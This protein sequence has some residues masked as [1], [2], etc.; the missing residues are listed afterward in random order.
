MTGAGTYWPETVCCPEIRWSTKGGWKGTGYESRRR[1]I[2]LQLPRTQFRVSD[3]SKKHSSS[4]KK[5]HMPKFELPILDLR[6]WHCWQALLENPVL[7]VELHDKIRMKHSTQ[8]SRQV[9]KVH[10]Y[11][12]VLEASYILNYLCMQHCEEFASTARLL[13]TLSNMHTK[14]TEACETQ[15]STETGTV[16]LRWVLGQQYSSPSVS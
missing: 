4:Y 15:P 7:P 6:S 3:Q 2:Q 1:G 14:L 13:Q 5:M 12:P 8:A 9:F 10:I 16:L 11:S